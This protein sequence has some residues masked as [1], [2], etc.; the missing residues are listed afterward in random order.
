MK[1]DFRA[2]REN[3]NTLP[4]CMVDFLNYLETIKG[5]SP[6]TIK[7]YKVD[8][9]M[10]FRF[11]KLYKGI[12]KDDS[13]E[14]EEICINDIDNDFLRKIKLADLYAFM[15]FLEKYRDNS[16]HARARKVATLRSFFKYSHGKA[17]ILDENLALELEKPKIDKRNPAYLTLEESKKLLSVIDG[18]NK[19]RDY[20]VIT[21]FLNCGLRIS[22]LCSINISKI[23]GDILTIIGKG[24]KERTVYLNKACMKA[25]DNYLKVRN[26]Y[27]DKIPPEHR[28]ILFLNKDKKGISK[29]SIEVMVKKYIGKAGL[30]TDKYTPHK[31]RH[32]AATLM[33]KHG[34]VDIRSLQQILGHENIATTQIYTHVDNERLREAVKSNP[35]SDE[36]EE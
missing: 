18:P 4:E 5:K 27:L 22:E 36:Y 9:T 3:S 19:A 2:I 29:R 21:L 1:L 16:A 6:N 35:L 14:F 30:D 33:Y 34:N 7:G 11:L 17:K 12:H 28:D 8:L 24:N 15:S 31:L 32:T 20:C 26:E 13:M 23:K 25:I 10:F